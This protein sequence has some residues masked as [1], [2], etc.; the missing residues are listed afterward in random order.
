MYGS[1]LW[2]VCAFPG[3]LWLLLLFVVPLYAVVGVAFGTL[4]PIFQTAIPIWNPIH[5]NLV[6]AYHVLTQFLPGHV[7][8]Y[9]FVRTCVYIFCAVTISLLIAYPVAYYISRHA[10]RT[11]A[12]LIVLLLLPFWVSYLLRMLAWIGLLAPNGMINDMLIWL[13][14]TAQPINWL[15]G[16]AGTVIFGLIYGYIPYMILPLLGAL[17]RIDSS[18]IEASR[19]LGVGT[20]GTFFRVTLPLSKMGVLGGCV[21]VTLPMFGDYYTTRLLSG[22]PGTSMLGNQIYLYF[23]RGPQPDVVP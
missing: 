4:D 3:V 9:V 7:Y 5:W 20:V 10:R 8:W 23:H 13:H 2:K 22:T 15:G 19:D 6:N 17:D 21:I 12:L 18:L 14:L 11:K 1:W 16:H